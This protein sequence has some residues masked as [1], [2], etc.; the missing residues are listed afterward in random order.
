MTIRSR[1]ATLLGA[2]LMLAG[3][4]G[5]RM[6]GLF[7]SRQQEPAHTGSIRPQV[8]MSERWVLVS[9]GRG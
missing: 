8:D 4:A 7:G 3:C 5:D 1:P 2:L 6:T 9:P